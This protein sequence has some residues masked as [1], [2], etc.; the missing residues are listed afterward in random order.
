M[1]V[2]GNCGGRIF[3]IFDLRCFS[4]SGSCDAFSDGVNV[5]LAELVVFLEESSTAC[6]S[7]DFE[8][9]DPIGIFEVD[10]VSW[11][12]YFG[13]EVDVGFT[14]GHG[15]VSFAEDDGKLGHVGIV[16]IVSNRG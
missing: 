14:V 10:F 9:E 2:W 3:F 12:Q 6:G 1:L 7:H 13:D 8:D 4:W 5:E 11:G 15:V 16:E